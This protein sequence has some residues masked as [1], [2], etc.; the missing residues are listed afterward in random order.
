VLNELLSAE[1]LVSR[2]LS[3]LLLIVV[4][5]DSNSLLYLLYLKHHESCERT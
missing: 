5:I 2:T 4:A 1:Q 3:M